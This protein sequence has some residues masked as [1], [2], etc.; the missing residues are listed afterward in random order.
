MHEVISVNTRREDIR[1]VTSGTELLSPLT[2]TSTTMSALSGPV[3][4]TERVVRL[5][6]R[7]LEFKSSHP[8]SDSYITKA[9]ARAICSYLREDSE[10]YVEIPDFDGLY[11]T[12]ETEEEARRDLRGALEAWLQVRSARGLPVPIL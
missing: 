1:G 4:T 3:P 7:V 8:E 6:I 10:F 9:L 5:H 2:T 12:G 11:A